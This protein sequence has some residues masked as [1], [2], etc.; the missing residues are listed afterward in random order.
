MQTAFGSRR[1]EATQSLHPLADSGALRVSRLSA[2]KG[3]QGWRARHA[4]VV[5]RS[6]RG[7]ATVVTALFLTTLLGS[8]AL[9]I[10]VGSWYRDQR[11]LQGVAD[12]AVLAAAQALPGDTGTASSLANA[13][14]SKNG[15]KL[16]TLGFSSRTLPSDTVSVTVE[17]Q[18][19]GLFTKLFGIAGVKIGVHAAA[20][21]ALPAQA[22]LVSPITIGEDTPQLRC[23]AAC[24]GQTL[25]LVALPTGNYSGNL[26]NFSLVNLA[27]SGTV[28]SST[29]ADWLRNGYQGFLPL[30]DYVGADTGAFN[31]SEFQQALQDRRTSGKEIIVLIH[32]NANGN[33][34]PAGAR[35]TVV[36]WAAFVITNWSSGGGRTATMTGY[37]TSAHIGG[38]P[39]NDPN[40]RDYGVRT[41]SLTE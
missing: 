24:Y 1:R 27:G 32:S 9:V 30:G 28:S 16:A 8:G 23:G 26:T 31:S 19:P 14:A 22:R 36:G 13:Y 37:F 20:R 12:A 6:E 25:S 17:D 34:G 38:T 39:S 3:K 40:Q 2:V 29:L 41:V 11:S 5:L 21:A 35:Y 4:G 33:E 15:G 7:V 10:D 18:A